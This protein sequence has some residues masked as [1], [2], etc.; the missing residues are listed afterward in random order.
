MKKTTTPQG[1]EQTRYKPLQKTL[2]V[3]Q[4]ILMS[5]FKGDRKKA[6]RYMQAA[7]AQII[8]KLEAI[9]AGQIE[10]PM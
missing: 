6:A 1:S 10:L 2:T 7:Y 3:P 8:A 4:K 5:V 9:E